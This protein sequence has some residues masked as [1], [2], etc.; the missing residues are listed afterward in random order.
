[1]THRIVLA[2]AW[3]FVTA[4]GGSQPG[5]APAGA[6]SSAGG[7]SGA[8]GTAV[9]TGGAGAG[10]GGQGAGGQG[11]GTAGQGAGTAGQSAGA[12]A[13]GQSGGT[14][15]QSAG[16]AGQSAGGGGTAGSGGSGG[17]GGSAPGLTLP[18]VRGPLDVL[19]MGPL[20]FSVDPSKSARI[21]SFKLDGDELLTDPTANANFFG[22]TLWTSPA[23]DWVVNGPMFVPQP[24]V[25]D[26]P[27]TTTVSADGVI[28]ATSGPATTANTHK[29][30]VVIKTFHADL[31]KNAIVINY[32][33]KNTGTTM[34]QLSHWEVTRVFTGGLTF[35]PTGTTSKLNFLKQLVQVTQAASYTW[36][37]NTT[38]KMGMGESKAGLDS[39]GGFIAHVA[40]HT[41]GDLLFI[42]AFKA[43]TVATAPTGHYP[44]E[45]YCNDPHT[46]VELEDHSS[47]DEIAPG[48]TYTQTVTWY[49]RRLPL[50]TDRSAGSAALIAAANTTLGK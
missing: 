45:I 20:S 3:G 28:T 38:H 4:C 23:D 10:A 13:G 25:D 22:S 11:A 31:A 46:Y 32:G 43:I 30:F 42:K 9:S 39:P 34:F 17:S 7:L 26:L 19:E 6:G 50:N 47:Y 5:T 18:I 49:L 15:G 35:F 33:L 14:G 24:V 41:K 37:D 21:V 29:Q 1:M 12:G 8:G 40:P 27:Y 48:A 16:A 44:I 2:L 36:Y